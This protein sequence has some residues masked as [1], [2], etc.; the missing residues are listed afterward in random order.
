M[1]IGIILGKKLK[2]IIEGN[3]AKEKDDLEST[4]M[5]QRPINK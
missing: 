4:S 2:E 3:K 5:V 1:S